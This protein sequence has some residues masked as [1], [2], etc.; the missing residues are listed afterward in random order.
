MRIRVDKE[1]GRYEDRGMRQ[2][3]PA[4][5]LAESCREHNFPGRGKS[6]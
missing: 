1:S 2:I 3:T 4:L 5:G 6:R